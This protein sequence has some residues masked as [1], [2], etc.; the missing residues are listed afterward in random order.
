[1]FRD[2]CKSINSTLNLKDVLE[3]ITEN[4]VEVLNVK[5]CS[6]FLLDRERKTLELS[7]SNGLS[8]AYLEKG[9]LDA[10]KSIKASLEGKMTLIYDVTKESGIQYPEE[11][12]KEG[13]ASILS[14]PISIKDEI[15]GAIRIYTSQPYKFSEHESEFI[16]GLAEMSGIAIDNARMHD[17]LKQDHERLIADTHQWFEFGRV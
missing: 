15:I 2:V 14:V 1:M 8:P 6:I 17:Y 5:A 11:A 16:S 3:L 13:I 12:E 7:A 9:P 10:D 4:V